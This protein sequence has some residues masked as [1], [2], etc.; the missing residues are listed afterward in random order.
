[1]LALTLTAELNGVTDLAPIDTEDSPFYYTFKVQC[2]SCREVHPNWVSVSRFEQNE[3]SGS[4]G[5]ANFV[6][7]CKNCKRE[8][9]A[10]IKEAPKAYAQNDTPKSQKIIEIDCRG[11]EFVEFKP[12][13]E[14]KATGIDSNTKF[15]AIDLTEG[16]WYDY[17]EKAS[18][19]VSIQGQKWEIKRA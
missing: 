10:T 5:E 16:D 11:L 6:W 9:S 3:V 19:E 7:K 12:D 18:E 8:H 1:M 15:D 13:G 2:T 17:D 4:R 14:W